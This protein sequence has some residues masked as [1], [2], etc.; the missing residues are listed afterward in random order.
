MPKRSMAVVRPFAPNIAEMAVY[1]PFL[2]DYEV[3]FYYTGPKEDSVRRELDAIGLEQ[4]RIVRYR[5]YTD[6]LRSSFLQRALDFK[7]G[8]GSLMLSHV[9]EALQAD[10]LNVVDPIYAH[11]RQLVPKL[12]PQQKL[13]YT[14]SENIVGRYDLIH[15]AARNVRSVLSR[16]DAFLCVSDAARGALLQAEGDVLRKDALV[17]SIYQGVLLPPWQERR[18]SQLPVI[19]FVGRPQWSKGLHILLA[20]FGMVTQQMK[21]KARLCVIG[22]APQVIS[23]QVKRLGIE[24]DIDITGRMSNTEVRERMRTGSVYCFPS[25]VTVNWTEQFGYGMVEAMSYGLPIVANYSGSIPEVC[26]PDGVYASTGNAFS[27]AQALASVLRSPD[28]GHEL[29]L[30]MRRRAEQELDANKQGQK[31]L[32]ATEEL[33]GSR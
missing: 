25:L 9:T 32:A 1:R 17:R 10:V 21:V 2:N 8:L 12:K 31:L 28:G 30:R 7:V 23:A 20:A 29:G 27:L 11:V 5:G 3:T 22:I 19:L 6:H 13:V 4:M 33:F 14:I 18:P 24:S 15:L 26:G 16:G